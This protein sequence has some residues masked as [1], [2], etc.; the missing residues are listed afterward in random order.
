MD[1]APLPEELQHL[2]NI[3]NCAK[4]QPNYS[5]ETLRRII[6][7]AADNAPAVHVIRIAETILQCGIEIEESAWSER[8]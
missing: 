1:H 8:N 4:N 3:I 5:E 6:K 7:L 2:R